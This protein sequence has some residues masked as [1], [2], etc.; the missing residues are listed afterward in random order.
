MPASERISRVRGVAVGLLAA[1]ASAWISPAGAA[2]QRLDCVLTDTDT[3]RGGEKRAIAIAFDEAS[4]TITLNENDQARPLRDVAISNSSMSGGVDDVSVGVDR[5]SLRVVYQVY[6]PESVVN[7][8]GR[9]TA[10]P[11]P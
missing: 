4:R 8:F 11:P 3:Q 1:M 9:C 6:R 5:S 7:E 10:A 2:P